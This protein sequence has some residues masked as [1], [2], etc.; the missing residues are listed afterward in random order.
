MYPIHI[1][2]S[3]RPQRETGFAVIRHLRWL[4]SS[5][6]SVLQRAW[7]A[8]AVGISDLFSISFVFPT[9]LT[10]ERIF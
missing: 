10:T 1:V 7:H 9:I 5:L 8:W 4:M 3:K 6:R 2:G